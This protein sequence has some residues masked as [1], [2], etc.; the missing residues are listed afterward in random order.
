MKTLLLSLVIIAASASTIVIA[1]LFFADY[2]IP[3][4]E[5]AVT[6]ASAQD[7]PFP[8][9]TKIMVS[10]MS[11]N[12]QFFGIL[13]E[14]YSS[15]D[16]S[17][18]FIPN[19]EPKITMV[20]KGVPTPIDVVIV[21][22]QTGENGTV[23]VSLAFTYCAPRYTHSGLERP[24]LE[25]NMAIFLPHHIVSINHHFNLTITVPDSVPNGLY[26]LGLDANALIYSHDSVKPSSSGSTQPFWI[27][28]D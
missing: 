26:Q 25:K 19:Q 16:S 27:R 13:V 12:I 5:P 17:G 11:S 20:K 1:I 8:N 9:D 23:H 10:N 14:N 4:Q 24:C 22:Y 7:L 21:P 6:I 18:N 28:V 2:F 15:L 3:I